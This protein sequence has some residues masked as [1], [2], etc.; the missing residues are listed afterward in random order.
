MRMHGRSVAFRSRAKFIPELA[1]VLGI[2]NFGDAKIACSKTRKAE[3]SPAVVEIFRGIF[4]RIQRVE[5]THAEVA[6]TRRP[7]FT[8][9]EL[10]RESLGFGIY[11]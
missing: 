1:F 10:Q 4:R 3:V 8:I 2:K 9:F 6:D 11:A 7:Y 5:N